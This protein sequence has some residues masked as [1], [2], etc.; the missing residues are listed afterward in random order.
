MSSF[1]HEL[2][3]AMEKTKP[4]KQC[5]Y[6][7]IARNE[8]N[9]NRQFLSVWRKSGGLDTRGCQSCNGYNTKCEVYREMEEKE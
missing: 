8:H 4:Y 5:K 3:K 7:E 6:Y 1:K 2:M 9:K